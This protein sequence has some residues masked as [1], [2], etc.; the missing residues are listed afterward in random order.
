M[1]SP[2][3]LSFAALLL[4]ASAAP[5]LFV[6]T[7]TVWGGDEKP[8]A[9]K[10]A[11]TDLYG[12]PLP[13]GAIARLG[14]LR[15]RG[16]K[17]APTSIEGHEARVT[18][19]AYSPDGA[20]LASGAEDGVVWLWNPTTGKAIRK[21]QLDSR[22][23]GVQFSPD[24]KTLATTST[25]SLVRLWEIGTGKK[26]LTLRGHEHREVTCVAFSP[27]GKTVASSA[28]DGTVRL[29]DCATGN[30]LHVLGPALGER[31]L[32]VP[33]VC[34]AFALDGNLL[35][36]GGLDRSVLFWEPATGKPMG[37]VQAAGSTIAS[38]A[39][40]PESD[41]LAVAVHRGGIQLFD[42]RSWKAY[43]TIKHHEDLGAGLA[44]LPDGRF[45]TSLAADRET[46]YFRDLNYGKVK[47]RI[48]ATNTSHIAV[49][50]N[51]LT[52]ATS[53]GDR[54]ILIRKVPESL[55]RKKP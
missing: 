17:G 40:A 34:V 20:M 51:G 8:S 30:A 50:P 39:F 28:Y 2:A 22:A 54:A 6:D 14:T 11:R 26:R 49:C 48:G 43:V 4:A 46:I 32:P 44:W 27:G 24:G 36:A 21:L 29:W 16:A 55:Q 7:P 3:R 33:L 15:P 12:D 13:E 41:T 9:E 45:F 25:D 18:C 53:D 47:A 37:T 5:V 10:P 38:L 19:L 52:I 23:T 1:K 42:L 35:A 31:G